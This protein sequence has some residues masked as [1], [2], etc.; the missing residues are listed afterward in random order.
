LI[1][2]FIVEGRGTLFC[3][4]I[5]FGVEIRA[6]EAGPLLEKVQAKVEGL[7]FVEPLAENRVLFRAR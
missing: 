2:N 3:F 6:T 1:G 4:V 7:L 5:P